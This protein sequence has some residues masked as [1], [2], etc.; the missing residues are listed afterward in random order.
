MMDRRSRD[1]DNGGYFPSIPL[2]IHNLIDADYA[3]ATLL[4][5]F[6]A[7][8]GRVSA[9]QV[10]VMSFIQVR[11]GREGRGEGCVLRNWGSAVCA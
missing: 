1:A 11:P 6:G 9:T 5:S 7:V 2:A 10:L 4:I 3:A 8:I